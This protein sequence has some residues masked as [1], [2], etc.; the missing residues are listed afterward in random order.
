M[1]M[2]LIRKLRS[3]RRINWIERIGLINRKRKEQGDYDNLFQ[4]LKMYPKKLFKWI[5]MDLD[6]LEY[7]YALIFHYL[8]KTHPSALPS[9]FRFLATLS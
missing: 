5:R 1:A 8:I 6:T 3:D 7:L 2:V 4:D 9:E